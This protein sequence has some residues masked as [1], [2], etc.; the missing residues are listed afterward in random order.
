[1]QSMTGFGRATLMRDGREMTV[2]LKS[3]NHRYLDL[4]FR[5]PRSL[6]FLEETLRSALGQSLARGHVDVYVT[7]RNTREDAREVVFDEALGA[8]YWQAFDQVRSATG[9]DETIALSEFIRIPDVLSVREREEDQQ[10]VITLAQEVLSQALSQLGAARAR[11]GDR[12]AQD[13]AE[14]IETIA[15]LV[16]DVEARSQGVAAQMKTK[17]TA[18][19]A[20]LM[21]EVAP[22]PARIAQEV[23]I[24]ADKAAI[25]EETV[26]LRSH[27][28]AVR[29]TLLQK[30]AAGRRLDF[31]VQEMNREVNTIGSKANDLAVTQN[32]LAMKG[33]IEKIRE[34]VQNIE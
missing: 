22:D 27:L 10:A 20:E 14:R 29:D 30:E 15:A 12:L 31:I 26:R 28:Q 23:A 11:E 6:G 17:L 33:E 13:I 16:T 18:R 32:V 34:Q 5:M 19:I 25:D 4:S 7:Y 1:M 24:L 21:G 9:L 2:E 8:A 3:V